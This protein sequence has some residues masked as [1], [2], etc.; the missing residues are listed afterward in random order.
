MFDRSVVVTA[1]AAEVAALEEVLLGLSEAEAVLPTRCVPW[2][3]AAL[4]VHTVGSLH[5]VTVALDGEVP[6]PGLSLVSAAGY[7]APDVRFSPEVNTKRVQGA[8][9][10]AARRSDATEP[11]RVL[12]GVW[13]ALGSRL[14]EEPEG[15]TMMTRHGDPMLL[16]DY[17]VTRVVEVLLHGVD[18]ADALGREPW[19][20]AEGLALVR[21]VLFGAAD[22][23]ALERVLPGALGAR[24]LAAVRVVTG[25]APERLERGVLEGVGVR[26]LALG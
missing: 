23:E 9:A 15:R 12:R 5:Q 8:V 16:T 25:R 3:A 18:L 4:A 1:L 24:S 14:A 21:E 6:D 19:T 10:S 2:D 20:S 17:L 7:Y 11:G 13:R 22:R 26:A